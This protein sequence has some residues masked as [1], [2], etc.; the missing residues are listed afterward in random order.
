MWGAEGQSG[1]VW[2][3]ISVSGIHISLCLWLHTVY[4][5]QV[6]S[7]SMELWDEWWNILVGCLVFLHEGFEKGMQNQNWKHRPVINLTCLKIVYYGNDH[8]RL[9]RVWWYSLM[10][11]SHIRPYFKRADHLVLVSVPRSSL[12]IWAV[13]GSSYREGWSLVITGNL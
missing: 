2:S 5:T 1:N 10:P 7:I 3:E 8:T 6:K 9:R 4:C 12:S 13:N 11:S